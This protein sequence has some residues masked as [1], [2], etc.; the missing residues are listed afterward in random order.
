[1]K[2]ALLVGINDY[3][4]DSGL[5][6]L[7]Y[8]ERDACKLAKVLQEEC[9]FI[10][11]T[12]TGSAATREA[13]EL[14]LGKY[15]NGDTLLF[16][17]AGHGQIINHQYALHPAG[18]NTTSPHPLYF[19][20]LYHQW[21]FG[22]GFKNVFAILD[23]C[24]YEMG[25]VR[26]CGVFDPQSVKEFSDAVNKAS[27]IQ[28][29]YGCDEGRCSYEI[30]ELRHGLLTYGI[31]EVL[32][33][34][35]GELDAKLLADKASDK[36]QDW[37]GSDP[38]RREQQAQLFAKPSH[39]K[40]IILAENM[41]G[42]GAGTASNSFRHMTEKHPPPTTRPI[43]IEKFP[44]YNTWKEQFEIDHLFASDF[45]MR[46]TAASA[47]DQSS[48]INFLRDDIL[49]DRAS[50]LAI[51][52]NPQTISLWRAGFKKGVNL[53]SDLLIY[54][55]QNRWDESIGLC[56]LLYDS[57]YTEVAFTGD[58]VSRLDEFEHLCLKKG[59]NVLT[60]HA[61]IDDLTCIT[62]FGLDTTRI[63]MDHMDEKLY[64]IVWVALSE[65]DGIIGFCHRKFY[66]RMGMFGN[67]VRFI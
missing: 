11:K 37:A 47:F 56:A 60:N 53:R 52:F 31:L 16:Y 17:F 57:N 64:H 35:I 27:W 9:G 59:G 34:H 13:I 4:K 20:N 19:T 8:A 5:H 48:W 26:G 45:C 62:P 6:P 43:P 58:M 44:L 3:G 67:K 30:D 65:T 63:G 55:P 61:A 36:M 41:S 18:S 32:R 12:L 28:I 33:E 50:G 29:L 54:N 10:T 23:S 51:G 24:R 40:R 46:Q 39:R 66:F 15:K 2:K 7:K 22:S 14:E 42:T 21:Q 25:G 1:M 49:A 38:Q